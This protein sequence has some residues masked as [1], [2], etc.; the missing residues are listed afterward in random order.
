MSAATACAKESSLTFPSLVKILRSATET[1]SQYGGAE[2]G[3]RTMVGHR[4][5]SSLSSEIYIKCIYYINV[6]KVIRL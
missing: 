2:R 1:L 3:D 6:N 5:K 4:T